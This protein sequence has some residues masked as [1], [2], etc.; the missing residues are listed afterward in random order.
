MWQNSK[1]QNFDKTQQLKYNKT[2]K[3]C[4]KTKK[5]LFVKNLIR[6]NCGRKK[7]LINLKL[8][9]KILTSSCYKTQKL[10]L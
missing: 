8:W 1:T 2:K 7:K 6:L 10:E 3:K 9:E 5:N 4:D